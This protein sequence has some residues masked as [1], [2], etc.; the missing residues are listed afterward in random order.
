[1]EVTTTVPKSAFKFDASMS[2]NATAPA[3]SAMGKNSSA[4]ICIGLPGYPN[5]TNTLRQRYPPNVAVAALFEPYCRRRRL[6]VVTPRAPSGGHV[7]VR[8]RKR[9]LAH[10]HAERDVA[11][12]ELHVL[13]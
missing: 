10:G 13:L 11:R 9:E 12:H 6:D 7:R 1:M 4:L 2:R 8:G 3:F 5:I